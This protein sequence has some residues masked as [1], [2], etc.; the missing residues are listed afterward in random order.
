M[1]AR[2]RFNL[3]ETSPREALCPGSWKEITAFLFFLAHLHPHS[4]SRVW[5]SQ[6]QASLAQVLGLSLVS[7]L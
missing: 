7:S 3:L 1:A 5:Q 4:Q 6:S 2:S